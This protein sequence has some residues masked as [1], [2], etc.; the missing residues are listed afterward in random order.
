MQEDKI[1][2]YFAVIVDATPDSSHIKQTTFLL[3]YLHIRNDIYEVQERFLMFADG[4]SKRGIKI[5]QLIMDT[6]RS[7]PF[8]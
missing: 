6:L 7:T 1:Y 2:K 4:S 3:R 8:L 5:A